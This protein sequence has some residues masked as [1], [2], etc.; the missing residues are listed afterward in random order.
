MKRIRAHVQEPRAWLYALR[1]RNKSQ[2]LVA[3]YL[4]KLGNCMAIFLDACEIEFFDSVQYTLE[5]LQ[6]VLELLINHD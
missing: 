1:D 6:P 4:T 2:C 5:S 3:L